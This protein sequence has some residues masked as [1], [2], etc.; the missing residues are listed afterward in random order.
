[1]WTAEQLLTVQGVAV[2]SATVRA[3]LTRAVEYEC[4]GKRTA[5]AKLAF[6]P[7][8]CAERAA[9]ADAVA[10]T[11]SSVTKRATSGSNARGAR[12]G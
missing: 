4:R 8:C 12:M 11:P 2:T 6:S 9:L 3:R 5:T 7:A 10:A 1:M